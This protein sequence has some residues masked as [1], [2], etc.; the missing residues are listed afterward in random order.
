MF[1][2]TNKNFENLPETKKRKEEEKKREEAQQRLKKAK[3]YNQ[4]P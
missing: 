3:E 4:V 1:A 2:L